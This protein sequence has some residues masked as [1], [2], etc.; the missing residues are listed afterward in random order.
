MSVRRFR[1][2]ALALPGVVESAHMGHPD[3][4]VGKRIFA[5]LGHPD[6]SWGM[7]KLTPDEQQ[8]MVEA[9]PKIFRPVPGG[10]GK[11]GATNVHLASADDAS[12]GSALAMAW[13][14]IAPKSLVKQ[15]EQE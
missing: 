15:Y 12:L 3:F 11:G 2:M 7:V 8:V 6:K 9:A 10:W 13:K 4:R 14:R 1:R 5:T